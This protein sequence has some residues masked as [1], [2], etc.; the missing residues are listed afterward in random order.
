MK[1]HDSYYI[2]V[3]KTNSSK[4]PKKFIESTMTNWPAGSHLNLETVVDGVPIVA[5]G[6]KY[7]RRKVLFFIWSKG[8]GHT[9]PG[10]P[11]I[12]KWHD[13]KSKRCE[14]WID[15]PAV[16]SLY[17]KHC[18][19][20]DVAN[21]MRQKILRLEK[22]WVTHDGYFRLLTSLIG[23]NV[24]DSWRA[25]RHHCR[26]N[27]SHKN[28]DMQE[29]AKML[30]HDMLFNELP[31]QDAIRDSFTISDGQPPQTEA[32]GTE[33]LPDHQH[34]SPSSKNLHDAMEDL[35]NHNL[36]ATTKRERSGSA[37]RLKRAK[38]TTNGCKRKTSMFC[39]ECKPPE[40]RDKAWL[41]SKCDDNH[42]LA[43]RVKIARTAITRV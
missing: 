23:I 31:D 34:H 41:C 5:T 27:H 11:Y 43:V 40:S 35:S 28:L 14:R 9:E 20:I 39:P 15:R 16:I 22:S 12:A 7:C 19:G 21:M 26:C 4:Y 33:P 8:A 29:F 10:E 17:F 32:N 37:W 13:E 2:G 1:V 36:I 18:N 25:Y 30:G 3:V 6:Y 42:K 24:A 38:C